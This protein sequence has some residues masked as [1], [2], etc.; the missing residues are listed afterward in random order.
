MLK[1]KS[2]DTFADQ[3]SLDVDHSYIFEL[4]TFSNRVITFYD[5]D[6]LVLLGSIS[7]VNFHERDSTY[8]DTLVGKINE[9]NSS[10]TRPVTYPLVALVGPVDSVIQTVTPKIYTTQVTRT[11][12]TSLATKTVG[13]SRSVTGLGSGIGHGAFGKPISLDEPKTV[14][15]AEIHDSSL[16]ARDDMSSVPLEAKTCS[17]D[18]EIL[19][20]VVSGTGTGTGTGTDTDTSTGTDTGVGAGKVDTSI[21]D[22][23]DDFMSTYV[24]GETKDK[25]KPKGKDQPK[26]KDQPKG[27]S[28]GKDKSKNKSDKGKVDDDTSGSVKLSNSST[29]TLLRTIEARL[30]A[31]EARDPLYEGF[32]VS[33]AL[34]HQVV[35][36]KFKSNAYYEY[37]KEF[38]K[39]GF[40][41]SP[42][43]AL[44]L[45]I[46][47]N[48]S[49][50]PISSTTPTVHTI[51]GTGPTGYDTDHGTDE[52]KDKVPSLFELEV[53]RG[54]HVG[55]HIDEA[56]RV[57]AKYD[58]LRRQ[59]ILAGQNIRERFLVAEVKL[60]P[61]GSGASIVTSASSSLVKNAKPSKVI[62]VDGVKH[63]SWKTKDM[64]D[65][66]ASKVSE[67]PPS[68]QPFIRTLLFLH[69]PL[70]AD[71]E[72]IW[73]QNIRRNLDTV[74]KELT[75]EKLTT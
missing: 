48:I 46:S 11:I 40:K 27:K 30:D 60:G 16:D 69:S 72:T 56:R 45:H 64:I 55:P 4:C 62:L 74:T 65:F 31:C 6:K 66:I 22:K 57:I 19:G 58:V 25:V 67:F 12:T 75:M 37:H 14:D 61:V 41:L 1:V 35:R 15:L 53:I 21:G 63:L 23:S 17:Q 18:V 3:Y 71:S 20:E 28:K 24:E 73:Q 49:T 36:M 13:I 10:V 2:L 8:L 39:G 29:M 9:T 38:C 26:I 5:V 70:N 34:A 33:V 7:R 43:V 32:V 54:K 52:H 42:R 44:M 50:V 51:H 47:P 59:F 68:L